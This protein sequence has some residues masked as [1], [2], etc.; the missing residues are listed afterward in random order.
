MTREVGTARVL[1]RTC[2]AE[3]TRLWTV[4][5][6]W[7]FLAAAAVVLFGI[8]AIAGAE[9]ASDPA[10]PQGARTWE[11]LGFPAMPAQF[12]LLA[13]ALTAVTADHATGGI[14]P[15][16]QW[17]P[18]RGVLFLARSVV[19][20]GTATVLGVLL[21]L[22]AALGAFAAPHA[23]LALPWAG[24]LDAVGTVALVFA[25]GTALAVGLGFLLRNTAGALVTVFLAMLVL[26]LLLPQF[27]YAW[28]TSFAHALPGSGAAHLLL[29]G[30]PG[31]TQASSVTVLL[32][33]A[34]GALLLGWLRLV[35]TDAHR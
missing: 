35:R 20:V 18:R 21:A 27:G 16:L 17:T 30:I 31:M 13:L 28:T 10:P 6:T 8:D 23:E 24:A 32:V 26:P 19:A 12:A 14:V 3:W 25:A 34:A 4:R 9:A 11:V 22:A 7:L 2:A 15:T 33:W 1:A 29:G 5:S